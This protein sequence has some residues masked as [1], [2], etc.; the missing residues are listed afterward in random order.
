[1]VLVYVNRVNFH[2]RKNVDLFTI[3]LKHC[4]F[5]LVF[6]FG[7]VCHISFTKK[8]QH[9]NLWYTYISHPSATL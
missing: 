9:F 4:V 2:D 8:Q 5:E 1:M 7:G 6:T 3:C